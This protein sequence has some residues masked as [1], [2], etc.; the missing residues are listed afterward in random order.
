MFE[1][2]MSW[3]FS[4]DP[5]LLTKIFVGITFVFF[6]IA[7][8]V[9]IRG[10]HQ[11]F[12]QFAPTLLTSLGILG[13]F[14][15]ITVGLGNFSF[16]TRQAIDQSIPQ[17][18]GGLKMAF[19]TSIAGMTLSLLAK[20]FATWKAKPEAV[21]A[22]Q[23]GPADILAAMN[24]QHEAILELR[25]AVAG[26]G[27]ASVV[28]QLQ[29]VRSDINDGLS[30]TRRLIAQDGQASIGDR[31]DAIHS[32]I[33][34]GRRNAEEIRTLA[35]VIAETGE[36][37]RR[38][39]SGDADSSLVTQLQ[40]LRTDLQERLER[41]AAA[42][43]TGAS[44]TAEQIRSLGDRVLGESDRSVTDQ[45][46]ESSSATQEALAAMRADLRE[47]AEKVSEL[48]SKA[49]IE[50]L[51]N[52]IQDFN[53]KITEQFG[54][55]F[56]RLDDSVGKLVQWQDEYRSQMAEMKTGLEIAVQ[57]V[58]E[59]RNALEAVR[60]DAE[61]IPGLIGRLEEVMNAAFAY[62]D[63]MER[64]LAAFA[65]VKERAVSAIPLMQE[66]LDKL[67]HEVAGAV[68]TSTEHH[69]ALIANS[70]ALIGKFK[71]STEEL[72]GRFVS[73]TTDM[74]D[75]I[76]THLKDTANNV[77]KR[78]QEASEAMQKAGK[79]LEDSMDGVKQRLVASVGKLDE[80]SGEMSNKLQET[81]TRSFSEQNNHVQQISRSLREESQRAA[82][83]RTE[84]L[85]TELRKI[86]EAMQTEIA[87]IMQQ[88]GNA[89]VTISNKFVTDYKQF[90]EASADLMK[91][92]QRVQREGRRT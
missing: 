11:P 92:A 4:L 54:D 30:G 10:R 57:A 25:R 33:E 83:D 9:I 87:R 67:L 85:N 27:D 68:R 17:L 38:A 69:S 77:S 14:T 29:K 59:S 35:R 58:Q 65:E 16:E 66:H 34:V 62:L 56:K 72:Y 8:W 28:T 44:L 71:A 88:M 42:V 79:A 60:R 43:S 55:N 78:N 81:I 73:E 13:T 89:L 26:E 6:L 86:D 12:I 51:S 36:A 80:F 7:I 63:D 41:L 39:I 19:V 64:H 82:A 48:G 61:A 21:S 24:L 1:T 15:G 47:F 22:D 91:V 50:A 23:I 37:T 90:M 75:W 52:V 40:R 76:T 70:D 2:V 18:L 20:G 5:D 46:A 45:L 31:L 74:V 3:L 49:L 53:Q 32:T 84:L